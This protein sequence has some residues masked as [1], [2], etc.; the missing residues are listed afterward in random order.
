[1]SEG[2]QAARLRALR[3][4]TVRAT[5]VMNQCASAPLPGPW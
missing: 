1:M 2:S 5:K 4:K 3:I